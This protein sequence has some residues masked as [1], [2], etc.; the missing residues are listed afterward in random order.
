[1]LHLNFGKT[2]I[3]QVTEFGVEVYLTNGTEM[4]LNTLLKYFKTI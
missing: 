2:R 3:L 1:M 4:F